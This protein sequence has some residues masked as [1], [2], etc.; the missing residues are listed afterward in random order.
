MKGRQHMKEAITLKRNPVSKRYGGALMLMRLIFQVSLLTCVLT[1]LGV[2]VLSSIKSETHQPEPPAMEIKIDNF[3]FGPSQLK[4]AVG[5]G[6]I[7][8]NRDDI[9]HAVVSTDGTFKSRV[10]DTD[11]KFSYRFTKPGTY[12]YFS[13]VHP[14]MTGQV[15]VQ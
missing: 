4:V 1:A 14:K 12:P 2:G 9:P 3:S 5:T 13:S 10:L 11:D 8:V 6:V 7:W 15:V